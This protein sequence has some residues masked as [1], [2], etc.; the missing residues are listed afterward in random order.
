MGRF[1]RDASGAVLVL[2]ALGVLFYAVTEL[3][4][5]DY[6]SA[7]V[8]VVMGLGLLGA[9]VDLLRPSMGE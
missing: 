7:I 3:R 9:G 6:V 5:H 4:S 8:L 2:A 1:L